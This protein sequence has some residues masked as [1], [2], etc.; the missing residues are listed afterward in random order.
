MKYTTLPG[1]ALRLSRVAFG[2]EPLGGADWGKVNENA[3]M[4]AVDR[5]LELGINV[6]DTADVYGLGLSERRLSRVLGNHRDQVVIVSKFGINWRRQPSGVRA[7][8]FSDS[9]PR[10]VVTSIEGSLRRL[11]ID[12][13]PLYFIH[14]PDPG[15]P[16]E[17]TLE[18][19][20]RCQAAGKIR[21][22]GLSNFDAHQIESAQ[23]ILPISAV[24]VPYNMVE[25]WAER[26]ILPCC[27][28]LGIGVMAHSVL[29]QGLLTGKYNKDS[30]FDGN[31]RRHRLFKFTPSQRPRYLRM[32]DRMKP[33]AERH[34]CSITQ[35]AI[36]WVLRSFSVSVA[37]VG[38]K[39]PGQIEEIAGATDLELGVVFD[40]NTNP[41]PG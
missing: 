7:V 38:G 9:S 27:R 8:T 33:L 26:R 17:T 37:I 21:Y 23:R 12:C 41:F 10:H 14:R 34:Q 5:A 29:A 15:T 11:R 36:Q 19:L 18:V 39:T 28:K 22:I 35:V 32:V 4:D 20:G 3:V 25:R 16:L 6:F 1:T 2:C 13:I 30:L 24:Q 31:D 40:E